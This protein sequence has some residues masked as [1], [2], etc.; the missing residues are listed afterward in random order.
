MESMKIRL[1]IERE[2]TLTPK[3]SKHATTARGVLVC[4]IATRRRRHTVK[5]PFR[6]A[7]DTVGLSVPQAQGARLQKKFQQSRE[8]HERLAELDMVHNQAFTN[9]PP[10]STP[11]P[12][13]GA[14]PLLPPAPPAW[15]P[16][17]RAPP[18]R[19]PPAPQLRACGG[20]K[21]V[22]FIALDKAFPS[23]YEQAAAAGKP[24]P[25]LGPGPAG[26]KRHRVRYRETQ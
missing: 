20:E 9:S 12:P 10:P 17:A 15:A 3:V 1:E 25:D 8:D 19:A 11:P 4:A 7:A 26:N 23:D 21:Q 2:Y 5:K 22:K 24:A 18:A 16:P 6:S 14:L 13:L